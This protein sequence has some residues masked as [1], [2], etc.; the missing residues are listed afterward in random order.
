MWILAAPIPSWLAYRS[1]YADWTLDRLL[2][3]VRGED[4][5]EVALDDALR[6]PVDAPA[7]DDDAFFVPDCPR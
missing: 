7:L 2:D 1:R 5:V 3:E 6:P 4:P